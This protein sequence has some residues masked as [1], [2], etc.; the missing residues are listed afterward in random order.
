MS[1]VPDRLDFAA[2]FWRLADPKIT[3][4]SMSSIFLGAAAAVHA[5]SRAWGW[6]ALVAAGIFALEWA[7]N[8]SGEVFDFDSG[9][10]QAV[11]PEDRSPFSGGKRVLVDGLLTT[12]QTWSIAIVGYAIC[13]AA[14]L[15]IV[16]LREPAVLWLG[17][18]GVA[19]AFFYHAP[20]LKLAYRGWG[21]GAV[22]A[23]Y[24]PLVCAGTYLVMT[25]SF[26]PWVAWLAVP[27]G[28][29]I[30][31]FLW[32]NEFPDYRADTQAGKRT[33]VVRLGRPRAARMFGWMM[34]FA[35]VF[36]I[37]STAMGVPAGALGGLAA[38]FPAAAAARA[39][40]AHPED[41]QRIVPAQ[42]KTLLAFV[43]Y[44]L[45][46]GIGLIAT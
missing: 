24:G 15:A 7:K 46:A 2:G 4:A 3:L 38:V 14:G 11:A 45:G 43:L 32:I 40:L 19:L 9:A 44:A 36:Q 26:A 13:I 29:L 5:G 10:D 31:A 23:A 34:A 1:S 33:L 18:G 37:G 39:L 27:L 22:F 25:Q 6:L 30:A 35:F 21:E 20:P 16:A 12:R 41:T 42:A 17:L 28:I 8:A